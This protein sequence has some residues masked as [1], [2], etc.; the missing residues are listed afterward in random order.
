[1]YIGTPKRFLEKILRNI[2]AENILPST[3]YITAIGRPLEVLTTQ[4]NI[5]LPTFT[6]ITNDKLV[7]YSLTNF[8]ASIPFQFTPF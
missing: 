2:F 8:S 1:M 4:S 7:K 3:E 6:N 5:Y